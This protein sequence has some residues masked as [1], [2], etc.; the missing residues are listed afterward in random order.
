M[1][2]KRISIFIFSF[3][4]G[5]LGIISAQDKPVS[6]KEKA[7]PKDSVLLKKDLYGIRL[8]ADAYRFTKSF[9]DKNYKGFEVVGDYRITKRYYIAGELG[10]ENK[11]TEDDRLNFTTKGSYV[12]VGFDY[13]GYENWTGMHNLI[14]IG[15]RYSASTFS[16]TLNSYL[17][18]NRNHFFDETAPIVA[19][20]KFDGLSAQWIEVVAGVKVELFHN[21]FAGFSLRLNKLVANNKPENFDN[22]YIPGFNRTY[23]GDFGVGANYTITYLVPLYSKKTFG[24]KPVKK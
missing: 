9:L 1:K 13:N 6:E 18:Y 17:P 22:L 19:N 24:A 15:L 23:G 5:A 11:T 10:S 8:G 14:T 16:Q 12:K 4:F 7:K 3:F 21:L 20:T 2:M